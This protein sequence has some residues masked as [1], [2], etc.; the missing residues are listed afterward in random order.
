V[1]F[2][3]DLRLQDNPALAYALRNHACVL[4]V[5]V[6]TIDWSDPPANAWW[7]REALR[8]L[9]QQLDQRLLFLRGEEQAVLQ[10]LVAENPA[11]E[12]VYWNRRYEPPLRE[13]DAAFKQWLRE[14]GLKVASFPGNLLFEP[15]EINKADGSPYR[16]FT[17]FYKAA[18]SVGYV[19]PHP[20]A[21][22]QDLQKVIGV[23]P[24]SREAIAALPQRAWMRGFADHWEPTRAAGMQRL[25]KFSE[26]SLRDYDERRHI[27]GVS[28]CSRMSPWLHFGQISPREIAALLKPLPDAEPYLRELVWREFAHYILYHWPDSVDSP[29]DDRFK[30]MP[31]RDAPD[32][33]RRWQQGQTGIPL[34]DAGMRELWHTGFMHNR[35]R[36]VVASF[37]TKH[38]MIDWR[39]GAR[40]FEYTL[41]DADLANNRMGWQ[42]CAGS[43]VDAAPYFRVFNPALQGERFDPDGV[44]VRRWV[45]ELAQL[46]GKQL[47]R[48]WN[49]GKGAKRIANYPSPLVGLDEGRQR[50]LQQWARISGR[51]SS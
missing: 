16:V 2:R 44:Y 12:A 27:P 40:W 41:L 14:R 31:W 28:G 10:S 43:G 11:L 50:A 15:W 51:D 22:A 7:L 38:L 32:E 35:V 3:N 33:L 19:E 1:W 18:R 8:D 42:W 49:P 46:R 26:M 37:L 24:A 20:D 34:V 29:M 23:S 17:P 4:C 25:V 30:A 36:M 6:D 47:H 39:E 13:Q 9:S 45:P 5:Y 48:P 21:L